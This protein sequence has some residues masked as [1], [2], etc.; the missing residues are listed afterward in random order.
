MHNVQQGNICT[1]KNENQEYLS[2]F[3]LNFKYKGKIRSL[4]F[5][6]NLVGGQKSCDGT[7]SEGKNKKR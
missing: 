4:L 1:Q 2:E 5:H 7:M 3:Y 6:Q